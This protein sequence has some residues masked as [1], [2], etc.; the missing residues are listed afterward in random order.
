MTPP[1][2]VLLLDSLPWDGLV[3]HA[4]D[5]EGNEAFVSRLRDACCWAC[6]W[7]G[8]P[9]RA[10]AD[11]VARLEDRRGSLTVVCRRPPA[12]GQRD[13]WRLAWDRA[14]GAAS[15]VTF[16]TEDE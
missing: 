10:M 8:C 14:G 5:C 15:M 3:A 2:A 12:P 1:D 13:A 6:G 11:V 4:G 9:L 7:L 16:V